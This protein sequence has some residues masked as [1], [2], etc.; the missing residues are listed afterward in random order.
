MQV[1]LIQT[2]PPVHPVPPHC[3]YSGTVPT[4]LVVLLAAL[5]VVLA[6]LLVV[7]VCNVVV[8]PDPDPGAV[9]VAALPHPTRVLSTAI[10]SY[11]NVFASPP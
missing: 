4:A 10:S 9:V 3:P 6:A 5:L 1:P 7:L 11:Q 2:V 8:V